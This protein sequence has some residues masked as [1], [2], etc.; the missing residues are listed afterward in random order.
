MNA[1]TRL[2]LELCHCLDALG[3]Q[4]LPHVLPVFHYA[5]ALDVRVELAAGRAHREAAGIAE[6]RRFAAICTFRHQIT[7]FAATAVES[8]NAMLPYGVIDFKVSEAEQ[9]TLKDRIASG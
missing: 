3:T 2:G 6:H 1:G 4:I 7:T 9:Q 8:Q 5:D